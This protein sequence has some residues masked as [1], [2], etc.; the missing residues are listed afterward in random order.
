NDIRKRAGLGAAV[1]TDVMEILLEEYRHELAGE[2]SLWFLLRRSG[3]HIKYVK[4]RFNIT[5]PAGKDL[6]PIPQTEIAVNQ[7][8]VQNPGY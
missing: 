5:V 6:M 7:N 8:L 4:D 3:Q 1:G 2:M